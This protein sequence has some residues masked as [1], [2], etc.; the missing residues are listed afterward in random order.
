MHTHTRTHTHTHPSFGTYRGRTALFTLAVDLIVNTYTANLSP[1]R[2]IALSCS[3]WQACMHGYTRNTNAY[4]YEALL[5]PP[6]TA[7]IPRVDGITVDPR[8]RQGLDGADCPVDRL[9]QRAA[10]TIIP[11]LASSSGFYL[12]ITTLA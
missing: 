3:E 6:S 8:G 11:Y 2:V 9:E 10:D 7:F 12:K 1:E 5:V 4:Q